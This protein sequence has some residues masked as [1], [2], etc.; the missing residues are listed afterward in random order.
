MNAE[1]D[2]MCICAFAFYISLVAIKD[3]DNEKEKVTM[4]APQ[5]TFLLVPELPHR[6]VNELQ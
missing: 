5:Y 6:S 1:C 2:N 3:I 4:K